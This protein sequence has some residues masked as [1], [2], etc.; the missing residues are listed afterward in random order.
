MSF[1]TFVLL[2]D[3]VKQ[4][5]EGDV[6]LLSSDEYWDPHAIAGLLKSFLRELPA[7]ILTRELHLLF[8]SVIGMFYLCSVTQ[9]SCSTYCVRFCRSTR[10]DC[11]AFPFDCIIADRQLYITPGVDSPLDSHCPERRYQQDDDAQRRHRFQPDVRNSR[12]GLQSDAW[13]IQSGVQRRRRRGE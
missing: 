11:R 3:V 5:V 9:S 13:R 2:C 8:L 6:D 4:D 10:K 7:S 1:N 12:R